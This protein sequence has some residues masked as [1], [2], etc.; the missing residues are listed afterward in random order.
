VFLHFQPFPKGALQ[1]AES[2]KIEVIFATED[3]A[4]VHPKEEIN[5]IPPRAQGF[6]LAQI[7]HMVS[8]DEVDI[9]II[10]LE[11][12]SISFFH[13]GQATDFVIKLHKRIIK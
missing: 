8:G 13:V 10:E 11:F 3:K 12:F 9:E 5:N 2:R 6:L 1:Q 7:I 4:Q